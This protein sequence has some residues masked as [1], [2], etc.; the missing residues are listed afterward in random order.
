[1]KEKPLSSVNDTEGQGEMG[2]EKSGEISEAI[3]ELDA[4]LTEIETA[5]NIRKPADEK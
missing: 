2:P 5:L 4:R 1:M 3:R